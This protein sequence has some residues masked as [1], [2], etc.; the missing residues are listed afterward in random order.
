MDLHAV[1]VDAAR[2]IVAVDVARREGDGVVARVQ[3]HLCVQIAPVGGMA[4]PG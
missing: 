1:E 4:A 2:C 3:P